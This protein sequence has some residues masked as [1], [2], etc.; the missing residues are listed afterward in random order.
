M[1]RGSSM[2]LVLGLLV[3]VLIVVFLVGLGRGPKNEGLDSTTFPKLDEQDLPDQGVKHGF[4]PSKQFPYFQGMPPSLKVENSYHR[5]VADECD[6]DYGNYECRQKA[7]IKTMKDGTFDKADLICHN[8]KD[9]ED[10]YYAC[11]DSVYGNYIWMDRNTGTDPCAC[12]DG[13]QGASAADGSCYC[14]PARPLNDRRPLDADGE[15]VYI[16]HRA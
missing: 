7:Y 4:L 13:S 2:T 8:Y 16:Y 10:R 6:G 11:L 14:P 9:D 12:P 3:A 1:A 15:P 5:Y